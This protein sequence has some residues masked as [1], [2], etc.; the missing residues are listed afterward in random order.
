MLISAAQGLVGPPIDL[1]REGEGEID[2]PDEEKKV[3]EDVKAKFEPTCKKIRDTLGKDCEKVAF[4]EM[5]GDHSVCHRQ[6]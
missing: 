4:P 1:H 3:F 6:G 5:V 2:E